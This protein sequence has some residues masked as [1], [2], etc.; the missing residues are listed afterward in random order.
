MALK[1]VE[2]KEK[3][4]VGKVLIAEPYMYD[5]VFKRGVVTICDYHPENG[6][7]GFILNKPIKMQVAELVSDFPDFE[8]NV[9]Y[10]GPVA[11]D[12][13]HFLHNV[14]ELIEESVKVM[15]G[16]YWGGDFS[17]LKF[18]VQSEMVN[19]DNV[20]FFVGY[21]GWEP[22]QLHME[23]QSDSWIIGDMHPNYAFKNKNKKNKNLW[24][25]VLTN[26]GDTLSVIGQM[27]DTNS[28]N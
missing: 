3:D 26:M 2:Y 24:K 12:T 19:A 20:R 6:V 22:G 23:L 5:P 8:A 17:K 11:T 1:R 14:G 25:E 18:L 15:P 16:L 9:G 27:P 13:I 10:G 4:M 21:S 28:D 7:V